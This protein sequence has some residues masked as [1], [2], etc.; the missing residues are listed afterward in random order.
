[1]LTSIRDVRLLDLRRIESA[2]AGNMT[3]VE[4]PGDVPFAVAR[5]YYV[6]DIPGGASRG[7]HGHKRLE[8]V[9]VAVT[10]SFRVVVDDG[11]AR[12]T[13]TLSRAHQGLYLPQLLWIELT[14]FSSGAVCLVLASRPFEEDDYIRGYDE[15]LDY[16]AVQRSARGIR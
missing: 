15:F 3:V 11:E 4:S 10:G 13:F 12:Q 7:S 14:D 9:L 5:V 16:R 1:M 6:Y 8:R 2:S